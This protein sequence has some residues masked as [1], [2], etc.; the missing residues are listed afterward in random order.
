[1]RILVNGLYG[2][3]GRE[4]ARLAL[5]GYRG[6]ELAAGVDPYSTGD[7]SVPCAADLSQAETNVDCIVDFSITPAQRTFWPLPFPIICRW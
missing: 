5:D 3:M 2:H 7:F 6:A 1:M 4:I